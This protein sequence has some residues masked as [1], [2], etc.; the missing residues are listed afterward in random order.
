MKGAPSDHTW[1]WSNANDAWQSSEDIDIANGKTYNIIDGAGNAQQMLSLTQIG[2]SS[3]VVSLGNGVTTS[4][5]TSVG[6]LTALSLSGNITLSGGSIFGTS[7]AAGVLTLRS[8]SG[9]TN[10]SRI[11][12]GASQ[13]SDNGGVHFYT[14]GST[15]ATRRLTIKGTDG[16]VGIGVDNPLSTLHLDAT[17]GAVA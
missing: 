10:H 11:E 17:G 5:L 9:N 1:T 2:P 3:G 12:V 13:S 14:A 16:N 7:A 6:T 15:V 8:A 4:A